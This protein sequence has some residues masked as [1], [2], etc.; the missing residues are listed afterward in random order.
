MKLCKYLDLLDALTEAIHTA[1]D[2]NDSMMN[3]EMLLKRREMGPSRFYVERCLLPALDKHGLI[4][5]RKTKGETNEWKD[6]WV[7][8][9]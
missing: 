5:R 2:S 8:I 4:L 6:R 9:A 3:P 7:D 1:S